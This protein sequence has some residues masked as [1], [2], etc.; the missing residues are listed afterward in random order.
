MSRCW[1]RPAATGPTFL[2]R[3]TNSL[4]RVD[5]GNLGVAPTLADGITPPTGTATILTPSSGS[6]QFTDAGEGF[7]GPGVVFTPRQAPNLATMQFLPE[8]HFHRDGPEQHGGLYLSGPC[9]N[10]SGPYTLVYPAGRIIDPIKVNTQG[11]S[12]AAVQ[13][14]PLAGI[15]RRECRIDAHAGQFYDE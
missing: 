8:W 1:A 3:F 9:G 15:G 14:A 7:A 10:S 6:P 11:S 13:I 4:S 5:A 12:T 2:V